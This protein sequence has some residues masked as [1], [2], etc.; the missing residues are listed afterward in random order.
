MWRFTV[1]RLIGNLLVRI[2]HYLIRTI[3]KRLTARDLEE[4]RVRQQSAQFLTELCFF[5]ENQDRLVAEHR[6]KY[7]VLAGRSVMG[8]YSTP[9]EAFNAATKS[10]PI[11]TFMIQLAEPGRSA[12]SIEMLSH[13]K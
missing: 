12:Y 10:H 13:P 8:A 7:L 4:L 2:H 1:R 5:I 9:L 6:G 11:G 3:E